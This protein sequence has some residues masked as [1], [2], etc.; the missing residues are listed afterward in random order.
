V[1]TSKLKGRALSYAVALAEG[2]TLCKTRGRGAT[3]FD[4]VYVKQVP[5]SWRGHEK[6]FILDSDATRDMIKQCEDSPFYDDQEFWRPAL[7]GMG[8][9]IIDREKIGTVWIE[10]EK[11]WAA[12]YDRNGLWL[13]DDESCGTTRREAAMRCYVASKLGDD[14]DIPEG[15]K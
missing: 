12:S 6:W 11:T 4:A 10:R 1:K 5:G 7:D 14:V 2:H 3:T 15:L 13:K 9:H 8:D